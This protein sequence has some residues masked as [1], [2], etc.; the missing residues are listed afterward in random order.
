MMHATLYAW[1]A[2]QLQSGRVLDVGCEYGFG[3]ALAAES[4]P[5]V[6]VLGMDLDYAALRYSKKNLFIEELPLVNADVNNIPFYAE[7]FS[8]VFL[9]NLLHLV[10]E[11]E[12]VLLDTCR[13]LKTRGAAFIS[14]PMDHRG[15]SVENQSK[16]IK[17]L[18]LLIND[19]FSEVVYP[20]RIFGQLPS[21]SSRSFQLA[22][23]DSLWLVMCR[24]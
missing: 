6:Q 22:H 16:Y 19:Y 23:E 17:Q 12:R 14:V 9:I 21:Y 13:I 8:G 3:S 10:E 7:T 2:K 1:A 11:P 5:G 18:E 4:N 20:D 15:M 24:K